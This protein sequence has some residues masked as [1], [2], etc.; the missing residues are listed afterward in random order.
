MYPPKQIKIFYHFTIA[1]GYRRVCYYTNWAQYRPD[2]MKFYP[3]D[4]N[5]ALCDHLVYA[6]A[7]MEGNRLAPYEWNDDST[8]W[9]KGM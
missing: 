2:P 3:E 9:S 7:T 4:V 5:T 6:F 1:P 8:E